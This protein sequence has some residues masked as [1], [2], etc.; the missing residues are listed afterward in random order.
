M[1]GPIHAP[2]QR[3]ESPQETP[4]TYGRRRQRREQQKALRRRRRLL[5]ALRVLI[6]LLTGLLF[7]ALAMESEPVARLEDPAV[8]T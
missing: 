3:S 6:G 5:V 2:V 4:T 1:R 8:G 7:F